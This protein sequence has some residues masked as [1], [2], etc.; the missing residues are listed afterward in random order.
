[1]AGLLVC[2]SLHLY[3]WISVWIFARI[4]NVAKG[5]LGM[6]SVHRRGTYAPAYLLCI[7]SC[8]TGNICLCECVCECVS[9]GKCERLGYRGILR[10]NLSEASTISRNFCHLY[11][12]KQLAM[13]NPCMVVKLML[14]RKAPSFA[15]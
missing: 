10:V 14:R 1:M 9:S 15:K 6:T 11:S 8:F 2:F 7:M 12:R 4:L 5:V 13:L 3:F